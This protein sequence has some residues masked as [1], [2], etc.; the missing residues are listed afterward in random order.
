MS[1]TRFI[2]IAAGVIVAAGGLFEGARTLARQQGE[3]RRGR[4][5]AAALEAQL[6]SVRHDREALERELA[7]ARRQLAELPL[8]PD[9]AALAAIRAREADISTWLGR[10]HR[11]KE[12]FEQPGQRIPAMRLLT[13]EEWLKVAQR[14]P[15]DDDDQIRQAL[16]AIRGAAIR[17]FSAEASRAASAWTRAN[18]GARLS[19]PQALGPYLQNPADADLFASFQVVGADTVDRQGKPNWGVQ[20]TAP[21]DADYDTRVTI[22]AN[23]GWTTSPGPMAWIPDYTPRLMQASRAYR[24]AHPDGPSSPGIATLLDLFDPP[25]DPAVAKKV[26]AAEAVLS[27]GDR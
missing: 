21:V 22:N 25:L 17:R 7:Q 15:L 18:P 11:L 26:I 13:D 6:A 19:T 3:V 23:G 1:R 8:P 10:V 24:A 20:L 27:R 12:L 4:E 9:P 14:L 5:E 2:L 16:A